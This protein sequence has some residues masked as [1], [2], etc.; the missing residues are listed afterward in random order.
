ADSNDPVRPSWAV[1]ML[2]KKESAEEQALHAYALVQAGL[3]E[4]GWALIE[5]PK[6]QGP[7]AGKA[8]FQVLRAEAAEQADHLSEQQRRDIAT[9]SYKAA[10]KIDKDYIAAK[11]RLAEFELQDEK[12][13]D[14]LSGYEAIL[15]ANPSD[16]ATRLRYYNALM[17]RG[18]EHDAE[19]V[20]SELEKHA[21]DSVST[22]GAKS[23][24]LE[25][26]GDRLALQAVFEKELAADRRALWVIDRRKEL[27][28][29]KGD[30]AAAKKALEEEI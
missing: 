20:L 13:K 14:G 2:Q 15:E 28:L 26:K 25:L 9:K 21:S 22:L 1:T 10:L 3:G 5:D 8:W 6:V 23:R 7:L 12:V 4:E 27:A 17:D 24:W 19:L 16:E 30:A 11:R 18:Y 29:A